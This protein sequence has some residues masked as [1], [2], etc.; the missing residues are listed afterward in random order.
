HLLNG[1]TERVFLEVWVERSEQH[2]RKP[3]FVCARRLLHDSAAHDF[4]KRIGLAQVCQPLGLLGRD[5]GHAMPSA[6]WFQIVQRYNCTIGWATRIDRIVASISIRSAA[7]PMEVER[8][9][10]STT[11][12]RAAAAVVTVRSQNHLP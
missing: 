4:V 11:G 5:R 3:A 8:K 12:K 10:C 9:A 7:R 6:A 1:A 2:C